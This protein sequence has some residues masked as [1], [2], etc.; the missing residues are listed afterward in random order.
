MQFLDILKTKSIVLKLSRHAEKEVERRFIPPQ[1][2][3]TTLE[4]YHIEGEQLF[5]AK[6]VETQQGQVIEQARQE[7]IERLARKIDGDFLTH[8]DWLINNLF[9]HQD[10]IADRLRDHND[11]IVAHKKYE[12]EM[13]QHPRA[14]IT[15]DA[16]AKHSN[17]DANFF[18]SGFAV[19]LTT[20]NDI[21]GLFN[22]GSYSYVVN[23][24]VHIDTEY[25]RNEDVYKLRA[26]FSALMYVHAWTLHNLPVKR[27]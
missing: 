7:M 17:P 24:Q 1:S 9:E 3:G 25:I 15:M 18:M 12:I 2:V 10:P 4:P 22:F 16:P 21:Q 14:Q 23:P 6:V 27:F 8:T 26:R 13:R 11:V 5:S 20:I 19:Y